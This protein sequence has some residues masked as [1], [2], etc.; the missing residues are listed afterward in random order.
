[1]SQLIGR[2]NGKELEAATMLERTGPPTSP[3]APSP[4]PTGRCSASKPFSKPHKNILRDMPE[5]SGGTELGQPE[6]VLPRLATSASDVIALVCYPHR[7]RSRQ[8]RLG[9]GLS[10]SPRPDYFAVTSTT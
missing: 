10:G 3:S 9:S 8:Q 5:L 7:Q 1:M 6:C 2:E 4:A